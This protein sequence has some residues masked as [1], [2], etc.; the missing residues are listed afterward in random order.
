MK[1]KRFFLGVLV[2]ALLFQVIPTDI[3]ASSV[4]IAQEKDVIVQTAESA[5]L[6]ISNGSI[7]GG[8][9]R[10][11]FED[12]NLIIRYAMYFDFLYSNKGASDLALSKNELAVYAKQLN[13]YYTSFNAEFSADSMDYSPLTLVNGVK[14]YKYSTVTQYTH[15]SL[16]LD[17]T[18]YLEE[19][20]N[21]MTSL[22]ESKLKAKTVTLTE[23][24]AFLN[25]VIN[26]AETIEGLTL[27]KELGFSSNI[28]IWAESILSNDNY[29]LIMELCAKAE[30]ETTTE[31]INVDT[32]LSFI[33]NF[34][35]AQFTDE[36]KLE[37]ASNPSL[38]L[39]YLAAFAASSTYT[40][41][42]SY[43]G[44]GEFLAA[45]RGLTTSDM[46]ESLIT[47][48]TQTK[49]YRK[50]L[51]RRNL[52]ASG[53][54]TGEATLVTLEELID[55]IENGKMGALCTVVGALTEDSGNWVYEQ[56]YLD[57]NLPSSVT[58]Q[59]GDT[60][61]Y[62]VPDSNSTDSI[63]N[64]TVNVEGISS[65]ATGTSESG[66]EINLDYFDSIDD[67]EILETESE[68]KDDNSDT[69]SETNS[70]TGSETNS[71]TGSGTNS[72][73]GSET[74]SDTKAVKVGWLTKSRNGFSGIMNKFSDAHTVQAYIDDG[75]ST[76][77]DSIGTNGG[78]N[79]Y[80]AEVITDENSMSS[81]VMLYGTK[82]ARGIDNLTTALMTNII[83]GTSWVKYTSSRSNQYL[84]VNVYGD[85]VLEDDLVVL[86]AAANP[87]YYKSGK[88]NPFTVAFMN[89][90]PS[91]LRNTGTFKLASSSD[92]GKYMIFGEWDS[93]EEAY[94]S[95]IGAKTTSIDTIDKQGPITIPVFETEFSNLDH[96]EAIPVFKTRKLIFGESDNAWVSGST[97]E[98]YCPFMI[99][100]TLTV[101]GMAVFPYYVKEDT[102]YT[103]AQAV[104]ADLYAY[105][106]VNTET[107]T[108]KN[109]NKLNDSYI[110]D[111]A[112]VNGLNGTSNAAGYENDMALKY[113][114]YVSAAADRKYATLQ[115]LSERLFDKL[116][117]L[118]GVIG[119][120]SVYD[121]PLVGNALNMLKDNIIF[122]F[123]VVL[124]ILLFHFSKVHLDLLQCVIFSGFVVLMS[125]LYLTVLPA[126]IPAAFNVFTN[127]IAQSIS[128]EMI[129]ISA[130][131]YDV[132]GSMTTDSNGQLDYDSSSITLYKV[133]GKEQG[134]LASSLGCDSTSLVGGNVVVINRDAGVYAKNDE[135]CVNTDI[136]F[137]T[138]VITGKTGSD[139]TYTLSST[140]T[141]SSNVDYYV[142]YYQF[143]DSLIDK[144]NTISEIYSIPRKTSTYKNGDIKSNYLLYSYV[145][146]KPFVTP[147]NYD[148]VVPEAQDSWTEAEV[149]AYKDEGTA[150]AEALRSKFGMNVDWLGISSWIYNLGSAEKKTLWALTLQDLG[151]Y[152]ED[153]VPNYDKLDELVTY[154]NYQTKKFVFDTRDQIGNMSDDVM[155]KTVALRAMIAMT[156]R[157]SDFGH[158]MYPFTVNYEEMSLDNV[159]RCVFINDYSQYIGCDMEITEYILDNHGWLNLIVFDVLAI[160][161][162][163]LIGILNWS[164]PLFY[165]AVGI[166]IAFSLLTGREVKKP[167]KGYAKV[168][169]VL[170]LSSTVLTLL[171]LGCK[172]LNGSAFAMYL[173]LLGTVFLLYVLINMLLSVIRNVTELGDTR[174]SVD[175]KA[176]AAGGTGRMRSRLKTHTTKTNTLVYNKKTREHM[177]A[178]QPD[179]Y[180]QYTI[181]RPYYEGYDEDYP[182]EEYAEYRIP[183][184]GQPVEVETLTEDVVE[185][186]MD[187]NDEVN[188]L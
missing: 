186:L 81:P 160:M 170:L 151:Y 133:Q 80:A 138:L 107:Q 130:E 43:T 39:T 76:S 36:G 69:G 1:I 72:G 52:D 173:M 120:K 149:N 155:I 19:Y 169:V 59:S 84:Y 178:P 129:S 79:V 114:T 65:G 115:D 95:F 117:S 135:I 55:D 127:N 75:F 184:D 46:E 100:T 50:P 99:N 163:L 161:L 11:V 58:V 131:N 104:A 78:G 60:V 136:L 177:R 122:F 176:I 144:V 188:E 137:D 103:I 180:S 4:S 183:H 126:N 18:K 152:D 187:V 116:G 9:Q 94:T 68:S 82:Y 73:T 153:W 71:G 96:T 85:I 41:F 10:S 16:Q 88:Y 172:A 108:I 165:L 181:R 20:L 6:E 49:G 37:I 168:S 25:D 91:V 154:V 86:P 121:N 171:V 141:V 23:L 142:P 34:T 87:L 17:I 54:P 159:L 45:L 22:S 3:Y 31:I 101:N 29:S 89:S 51:Y 42:T 48:Y 7:V 98:A 27:G 174:L 105:L 112:V 77:E 110:I 63:I 70:G 179:R 134:D 35:Q 145:N 157:A 118:S 146:S 57:T 150:I 64:F 139:Y 109:Q 102:D 119:I 33:E 167:I 124:L 113:D 175:I 143:V 148:F 62:P 83:K 92:I 38:K 8:S 97:Y 182:R 162:F 158:W 111:V 5:L 185:D 74:D 166:M 15:N 140:K 90:Y 156:Q 14:T 67:T 53:M 147:G 26:T 47:L 30:S 56:S 125:Y 13:E 21:E 123:F 93:T 32:T 44:N 28:K 2:T 128:Y 40:P 12:L 106:T 164:V 61:L 132:T 66:A 24:Y